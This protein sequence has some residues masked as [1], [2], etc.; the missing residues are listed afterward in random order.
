MYSTRVIPFRSY[1][2]FVDIECFQGIGG[3]CQSL[4]DLS[5]PFMSGDF[6]YQV[7]L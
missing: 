5:V 4:I 3:R 6:G 2:Q 1:S 7:F